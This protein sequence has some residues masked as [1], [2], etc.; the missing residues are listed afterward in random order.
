MP[1]VVMRQS[2]DGSGDGGWDGGGDGSGDGGGEQCRRPSQ[3]FG[4][5][6]C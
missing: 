4:L 2:R 1:Q 3:D 5:G 6:G